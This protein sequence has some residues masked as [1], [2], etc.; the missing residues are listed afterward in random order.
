L[1]QQI[2]LHKIGV[3]RRHAIHMMGTNRGEVGHPDGFVSLF[4]ND[5]EPTEWLHCPGSASAPAAGSGG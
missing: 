2:A 4:I 3:Q 1:R 5:R